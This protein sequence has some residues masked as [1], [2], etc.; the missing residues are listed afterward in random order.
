MRKSPKL[1]AP[2]TRPSIW[3]RSSA[4]VKWYSDKSGPRERGARSTHGNAET[5]SF[6]VNLGRLVMT[7]E[8]PDSLTDTLSADRIASGL[9][10]DA[11]TLCD[12]SQ[13]YQSLLHKPFFNPLVPETL[14]CPPLV[15][16]DVGG[17]EL[18]DTPKTP[19]QVEGRPPAGGLPHLFVQQPLQCLSFR[20]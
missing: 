7:S 6:T 16:G 18:G 2:F 13:L 3:R 20:T 17:F 4:L 8:R 10:H 15:K 14:S 19:D 1:C 12:V 11:S 5:T 9:S